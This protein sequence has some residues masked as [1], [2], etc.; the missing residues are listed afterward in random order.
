MADLRGIERSRSVRIEWFH[1]IDS[2]VCESIKWN[3]IPFAIW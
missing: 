1:Q 3:I 2:F